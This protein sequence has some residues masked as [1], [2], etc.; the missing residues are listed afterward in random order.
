MSGERGHFVTFGIIASSS[1][2][3][4]MLIIDAQPY[5]EYGRLLVHRA[6]ALNIPLKTIYITHGHVDHTWR[7]ARALPSLP[8]DACN[9]PSVVPGHL[10]ERK[11]NG[12]TTKEM[13]KYP[14]RY[15]EMYNRVLEANTTDKF[16][17]GVMKE[18]ADSRFLF[19]LDWS[20]TRFYESE[21]KTL[22]P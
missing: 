12:W 13:V 19:R 7:T 11:K 16:W 22:V 21:C 18:F 5:P 3:L 2:P 15:V 17:D 1:P 14:I 20:S 10:D 4:E 8:G 9:D 6:K